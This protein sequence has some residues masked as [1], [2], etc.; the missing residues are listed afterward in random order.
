[1]KGQTDIPH[2]GARC[3]KHLA[4]LLN[5]LPQGQSFV[6]RRIETLAGDNLWTPRLGLG[7]PQMFRKKDRLYDDPTPYGVVE[8]RASVGPVLSH[9]F[10]HLI[11]SPRPI[12]NAKRLPCQ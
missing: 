2:G 11:E 8:A 1:M 7:N 10:A 6:I 3:L 5:A 9:P 12:L 4:G